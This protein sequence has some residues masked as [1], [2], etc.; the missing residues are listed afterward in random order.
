[1]RIGHEW[2]ELLSI[3]LRRKL[4]AA[5]R[6]ADGW[7]RDPEEFAASINVDDRWDCTAQY[8]REPG[9]AP[10]QI[11][12]AV[13]KRP[14]GGDDAL[15]ERGFVRIR[16]RE[17]DEPWLMAPHDDPEKPADQ[18]ADVWEW[19]DPSALVKASS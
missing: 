10:K 19:I 12:I 11:G 5:V 17:D 18:P 13:L 6:L 15:R 8:N 3:R 9:L 2:R 14:E 7:P 1:M 16:S 4:A